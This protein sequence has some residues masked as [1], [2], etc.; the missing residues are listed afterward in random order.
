MLDYITFLPSLFKCLVSFDYGHLNI[1]VPHGKRK[2]PNRKYNTQKFFKLR[3]RFCDFS[4]CIMVHVN[5][6]LKSESVDNCVIR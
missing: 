1:K 3:L 2:C 6:R 5:D 4:K